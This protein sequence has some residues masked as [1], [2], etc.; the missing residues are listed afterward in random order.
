MVPGVTIAL[1]WILSLAAGESLS[2]AA[3][4][5]YGDYNY[6]PPLAGLM[7]LTMGELLV[8]E[9]LGEGLRSFPI[10]SLLF[11]GLSLSVFGPIGFALAD[12]A[13]AMATYFASRRLFRACGLTVSTSVVLALVVSCGLLGWPGIGRQ[14]GFDWIPAMHLWGLRFPRPFLTDLFLILCL[15]SWLRVLSGRLQGWGEWALFGLYFGMLL[16]SRFYSAATVG[17]AVGLAAPMLLV[18]S[19]KWGTAL[20]SLGIFAATT[21]LTCLPFIAQRVFEIPDV[22]RR[23]GVFPV[24][25]THPLFLWGLYDH[26]L[27]ALAIAAA[28]AVALFINRLPMPAREKRLTALVAL[29]AMGLLSLVALPMSTILLG[30]SVQPYHF[31][32]EVVTFKTVLILVA[33]GQGIDL[34]VA[35]IAQRHPQLGAKPI[36]S[37]L[38]VAA[39]AVACV[40]FGSDRHWKHI[41]DDAH[42]RRDFAA[43]RVPAYRQAFSAL[44][45]ELERDEYDEAR[46]L[47]T[48][49]IQVLDWWSLFG[50]L[51]A[52]APEPCSTI[53]PD[54]EIED[55][56]L[57]LFRELGASRLQVAHLLNDRSV[58][59][60]FLGCSKYQA[61][62]GY[63]F[64]PISQYPGQVQEYIRASPPFKRWMIALPVFETMRLVRRYDRTPE[65]RGDLQLD[66]IVLGPGHLDEGLAP[67][68]GKY[69][70]TY[71]N[72]LF[73][74]YLSTDAVPKGAA[75]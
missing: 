54:D 3:T 16:Q 73:R 57:R 1:Y 32:D 26:P 63:S 13:V 22:P 19:S 25:R 48:L 68:G 42:E 43:Y 2:V 27:T 5:R 40:W 60:F 36:R 12:I 37:R 72:P 62:R 41:E 56:L 47:G 31:I 8:L 64:A 52:F 69:R 28:P 14:P 75:P 9:H 53:I 35:W 6:F 30:Q 45:E 67:P 74:V 10:P 33:L 70:L 49:D 46:V 23:F 50:G 55:R 11:H 21:G 17:M 24:D 71:E 65:G 58:L 7:H 39:V 61:S 29:G 20:R 66:L 34:G 51:H 44:T 15:G 4:Y 59:V 18:R 38:L